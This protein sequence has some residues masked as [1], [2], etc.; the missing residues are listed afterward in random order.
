MTFGT[1]KSS[2]SR[3]AENQYKHQREKSRSGCY[4]RS[5]LGPVARLHFRM[6]QRQVRTVGDSTRSRC[7]NRLASIALKVA[8]GAV[9]TSVLAGQT[10]EFYPL[11]ELKPGQKGYGRTIFQ[12]TKVEN[13]DFEV[14]GVIENFGPKQNLILIRVSGEK[15]KRTGIFA[16]MS[17]SPIYLEEKLV[18]AVAY[19]FPWAREAIAGVTPI[20]EMVDVFKERPPFSVKPVGSRNAQDLLK[21]AHTQISALLPRSPRGQ[22]GLTLSTASP[23]VG[24][25]LKPIGTPLNVSGFAPG[26][27]QYFEEAFRNMGLVP[28]RGI[29]TP[30]SNHYDATPLEPGST[31]SVQLVRGDIN[32][33]ASGTVTHISGKKIYAFGHPFMGM[34]YTDMPLN[35]AAVLTIIPHLDTSQKVSATTGF[36]GRIRQDRAT[37]IMGIRG[38]EPEMLPVRMKLRTS[39]KEEK[40][41]RYEAVMDTFLTPF[42]LT[43]TVYNSILASE[44]AIGDQTL[45]VKCTIS[46]KG[47]PDVEF[48]NSVSDVTSTSV[49]AAVTAAAPVHFLLNSGFDNLKM[50][51]V[52]IEVIAQ[53][54]AKKARL[55][56]V[57]QDK[58]EARPG[59][60]LNLTVFLRKPNGETISE[61]Y[62]VKIPEDITPGPLKIVVGDGV[63]LTKAD[64]EADRERYVPENLSQLIKAINNLKRNDRLYIRIFRDRQGTIVGGEGMPDLPP[65]LIAL[66]T[67]KKTSGDVHAVGV[68]VYVEHELPATEYVLEGHKV[69][70][71]TVKS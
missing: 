46:V 45:Q 58:L 66:Y 47:Q 27:I 16:G 25:Q 6:N 57:W 35:S 40:E 60:E 62:P 11:E 32:L 22:G 49:L 4:G 1:D 71:V 51:G 2:T 15:L 42:L 56:K 50:Q 63:S 21:P 14:L 70:E 59:E 48:E 18:G 12:G 20:R 28:V 44:R 43:L 69:I 67:S 64:V 17:G 29:G 23:P 65:S 19:A 55:E 68:A 33:S 3:S 8:L 7:R 10:P 30:N 26:A 34:G 13:F 9:F 36:V 31:I 54:K 38:E 5:S 39:R 61:K 37:G 53:E 41:F 24:G 52:D